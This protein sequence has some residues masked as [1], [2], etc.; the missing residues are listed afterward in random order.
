VKSGICH[1]MLFQR[2]ILE[3][4]FNKVS[5]S[6]TQRYGYTLP[7]W[8]IMLFFA[9]NLSHV[10][11]DYSEYDLYYNFIWTFYPDR[12]QESDTIKWD[13]SSSIPEKSEYTYLTAHA[14]LRC[15]QP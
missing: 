5:A 14:H 6:F 11:I 9:T 13:I 3:D 4:L 7:F 10:I 15:A 12:I 1:Q 2:T 8:K